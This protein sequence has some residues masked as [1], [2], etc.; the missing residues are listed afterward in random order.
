MTTSFLL[1]PKHIFYRRQFSKVDEINLFSFLSKPPKIN[2]IANC[3]S[4]CQESLVLRQIQRRFR[5]LVVLVLDSNSLEW[6]IRTKP[7]RQATLA[8]FFLLKVREGQIATV[9]NVPTCTQGL[10]K[11]NSRIA[12]V[13][14]CCTG[15]EN[16]VCVGQNYGSC[17]ADKKRYRPVRRA[18]EDSARSAGT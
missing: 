11:R 14:L 10:E 15:Q 17:V 16:A 1:P 3:A 2:K 8:G 13:F 7:A 12:D 4:G 5:A 18:E 6:V 9:D